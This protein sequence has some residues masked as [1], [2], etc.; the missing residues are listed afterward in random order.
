MEKS[1]KYFAAILKMKDL[2]KNQQ[3]HQRHIDFL[4]QKEKEGRIFARGRFAEGK[5]G[6]AIYMAE[7]MEEARKIAESD[8]YV[9]LGAR[10]LELYEWDMQVVSGQ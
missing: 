10:T 2:E 7:S 5:G 3:Y 8:P 1:M 6:L 4:L 9:A